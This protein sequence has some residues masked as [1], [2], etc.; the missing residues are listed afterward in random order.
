MRH[1]V[2]QLY[3]QFTRVL[4]DVGDTLRTARGPLLI[5]ARDLGDQIKVAA[6]ARLAA[7]EAALTTYADH[8]GSEEGATTVLDRLTGLSRLLLVASIPL[9]ALII[10]DTWVAPWWIDVTAGSCLTIVIAR[11]TEFSATWLSHRANMPGRAIRLC[12]AISKVVGLAVVLGLLVLM[13]GRLASAELVEALRFETIGR[14][15]VFVVA[16]G[17]ALVG[18]CLAAAAKWYSQ[19]VTLRTEAQGLRQL[20]K[21]VEDQLNALANQRSSSVI[22]TALTIALVL[23]SQGVGPVMAQDPANT[24][25]SYNQGPASRLLIE[26]SPTLILGRK[27]AS[28][29]SH[30]VWTTPDC[31]L[32]VDNTASIDVERRA[33]ALALIGEA[34]PHVVPA[35]RCRR[36]VVTWI[37]TGLDWA[38]REIFDIPEA[39]SD[40]HCVKRATQASSI[41]SGFIGGMKGVRESAARRAATSCAEEARAHLAAL[42]ASL[43]SI[44]ESLGSPPALERSKTDIYRVVADIL[45]RRNVAG[46]VLVTDLLNNVPPDA[47]PPANLARAWFPLVVVAVPASSSA[48]SLTATNDRLQAW[49]KVLPAVPI[50]SYLTLADREIWLQLAPPRQ[51]SGTAL[52][53]CGL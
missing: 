21:S 46:L 12:L 26:A 41:G 25:M 16:E 47:D 49:R 14:M 35:W 44:R 27:G 1:Q 29:P 7:I 19:P 23:L 20:V 31:F 39:P 52:G 32:A 3:K 50:V 51:G 38:P 18:G 5:K 53:T 22:G 9:Q 4:D 43:T 17:A 37:S 10:H 2:Q 28:L 13:L 34:L 30:N 15:A 48:G 11:L 40:S 45:C 6:A 36:V 8:P 33:D 42:N 24:N